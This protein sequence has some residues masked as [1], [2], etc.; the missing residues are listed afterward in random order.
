MSKLLVVNNED[1]VNDT[2]AVESDTIIDIGGT[3]D[4]SCQLYTNDQN[5]DVVLYASNDKVNWI[6]LGLGTTVDAGDSALYSI[7]KPSFK[8]IKITLTPVDSTAVLLKL[9]IRGAF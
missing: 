2:I 4:F 1:A 7:D 9:F 5:V 3:D 8:W 6:D